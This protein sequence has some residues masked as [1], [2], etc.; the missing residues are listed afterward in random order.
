MLKNSFDRI[1]N[2]P[3]HSNMIYALGFSCS[4]SAAMQ[5]GGPIWAALIASAFAAPFVGFLVFIPY[6]LGVLVL[7]I[8]FA[9][10]EAITSRHH[11]S[12]NY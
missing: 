11:I 2:W 1:L 12:H 5:G 4:F 10:L 6:F 7:A 3:Y 8:L 9:L